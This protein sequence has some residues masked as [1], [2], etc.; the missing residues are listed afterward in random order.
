M[1]LACRRW[2]RSSSAH[3]R[4]FALALAVFSGS[5][6]RVNAELTIMENADGQQGLTVY[7]M[8]VTPAG[9][10]EPA[11]RHRLVPG[12]PE[13]RPGNAALYYL[14]AFTQNGVSGRWK[15][16]LK[17][18]GEEEVEGGSEHSGWILPSSKR[19][20]AALPIDKMRE[21]IQPF[22]VI[23]EQNIKRGT[24]REQCDWGRNVEELEGLDIIGMLIP[25]VQ[26]TRW[27]SRML[28][29][30]ARVAIVD[31]DYDRAIEH[32]KMNYQLA[33]NVAADPILISGLV[34]I[35]EA[36]FG[37][38]VLTELMAAKGSPNLYWALAEMQRPFIDMYPAVRYELTW[39]L[40][41]FPVLL[42][43]E[44]EE[45]SPQEWAR[46][47]AVSLSDMQKAAGGDAAIY[48]D[49][50]MRVG[51]VGFG[52]LAYPDA[53]ARLLA[54]GMAPA[55]IERMPVGK[56]I[57]VDASREY[58]RVAQEHE[59]WWYTPYHVADEY[60]DELDKILMTRFEGGYGRILARLLMPALHRVRD[61]Q[62]R[63]DWQ[64]N[65]LQTV[66]AIR[67]HAAETGKLPSALSEVTAVPVPKNPVTSEDYAYRLD[68]D[69]A[70]LELPASDGF[71]GVAYRYEIKLVK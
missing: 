12:A 20:L 16:V 31:G 17:K 7:Q 15:E 18:Y 55:E 42:N 1:S 46:L 40:K 51:V 65:A 41:I 25:E 60:K 44:E 43:P 34:G 67:L 70:V 3:S 49:W 50:V 32:L 45:H 14:R 26:D 37:N 69:T 62:M 19:P 2:V 21:A 47:L 4:L 71:P 28:M 22:D 66:E 58:Q 8:T 54:S 9:A 39:G 33:R 53:K 30:R 10:S 13:M 48:K 52:L 59:K 27:L 56:V 23:I 61:N 35:L 64:L 63:L 24:I 38:L 5:A 68:G 11:F 29:L 36:N 6:A 57:A